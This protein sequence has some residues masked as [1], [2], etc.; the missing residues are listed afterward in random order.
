VLAALRRLADARLVM[1]DGGKWLALAIA[2]PRRP[3]PARRPVVWRDAPGLEW[4]DA[5]CDPAA[6]PAIIDPC[7]ST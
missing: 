6:R 5:G 4:P 1:S 7:V 3:P 2:A